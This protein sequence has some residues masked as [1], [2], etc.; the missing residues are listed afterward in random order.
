[1]RS[2][3]APPMTSME[4]LET[5]RDDATDMLWWSDPKV[6]TIEERMRNA[7]EY[8]ERKYGVRPNVIYASTPTL[9]NEHKPDESVI[10]VPVRIDDDIQ[11]N[12][13]IVAREYDGN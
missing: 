3:T 1:M 4:I 6:G 10:G 11:L 2:M 5:M 9:P 7:V 12:H 13:F 8:Y